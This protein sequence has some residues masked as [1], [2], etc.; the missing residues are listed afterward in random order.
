MEILQNEC[1]FNFLVHLLFPSRTFLKEII[2]WPSEIAAA[3]IL[4]VYIC[5][6][7]LESVVMYNGYDSQVKASFIAATDLQTYGKNGYFGDV[8]FGLIQLDPTKPYLISDLDTDLLNREYAWICL[9]YIIK[10]ALYCID[11]SIL[12]RKKYCKIWDFLGYIMNLWLWVMWG[13]YGWLYSGREI[14]GGMYLRFQKDVIF[15]GKLETPSDFDT[16]NKAYEKTTAVYN[17]F[18]KWEY[19]WA[20]SAVVAG[21]NAIL[22]VAGLWMKRSSAY[23]NQAL[24]TVLIPVQLVILHL[25]FKGSWIQSNYGNLYFVNSSVTTS[26]Y[27]LEQDYFEAR[28]IFV[29]IYLSAWAGIPLSMICLAKSV[30]SFK[31]KS[32]RIGFKY[33]FYSFFWVCAFIWTVMM[34]ATLY[35]YYIEYWTPLIVFHSI[36]LGIALV[37]WIASLIEKKNEGENYFIKHAKWE[38]WWFSDNCTCDNMAAKITFS[39][40]GREGENSVYK[41]ETKPLTGLDNK[42]APAS[43]I[44]REIQEQK[45]PYQK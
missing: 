2:Y 12:F 13:A 25:F 5:Q 1:K 7:K 11:F 37:L 3:T 39:N 44:S 35:H 20:F 17:Y 36:L 26:N 16:A 23:T 8:P 31:K 41:E 24:S 18:K 29:V 19:L 27:T 6:I 42:V 28:W 22:W 30:L 10:H 14:H 21:M 40:Q 32:N 38:K 15:N 34:D 43:N 9:C 4:L 33:L 45:K